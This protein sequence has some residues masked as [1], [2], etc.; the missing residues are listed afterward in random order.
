MGA[1]GTI[2]HS[3]DGGETWEQ[4]HTGINDN[5]YAVTRVKGSGTLW[6]VG[7]LGVVLCRPKR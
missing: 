1:S 4:E 5:L 7:Q 2:I 3:G 6:A